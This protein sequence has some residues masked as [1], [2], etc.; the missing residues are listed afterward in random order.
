MRPLQ[1]V[2]AFLATGCVAPPA[3]PLVQASRPDTSAVLSAALTAFS[4]KMELHPQRRLWLE[5]ERRAVPI[6]EGVFSSLNR[7]APSLRRAE[8][9]GDLIQ[10]AEGEVL[11][12]PVNSCP[13]AEDGV[14]IG[15]TGLRIE[16]EEATLWV[17]YTFPS[18]S[19][20]QEVVLT[21][22]PDSTWVFERFGITI[23]S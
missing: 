14:V 21:R 16:G 17:R 10:C 15:F 20:G 13:I 23:V 5:E 18:F 12:H 22:G 7:T 4:E 3:Q 2:L 9:V 1:I 8:A 19:G 6:S 11:M